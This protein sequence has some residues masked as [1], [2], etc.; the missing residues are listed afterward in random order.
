M[1]GRQPEFSRPLAVEDI[2]KGVRR[3]I[4]ATAEELQALAARMKLPAIHALQATLEVVPERHGSFLVR[5][6]MRAQVAQECVRTLDV[7]DAEVRADIER[8]FVPADSPAAQALQAAATVE[9]DAQA[10]DAPDVIHGEEIDLGELVAEYLAL[11]LDPWPKKPGTEHVDIEVGGET[12]DMTER[13]R[14]PFAV[15]DSL[16]RKE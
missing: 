14:H 3:E 1:S 9:L 11:S 8:L 7:F 2:G 6:Q 16:R 5:G 15:L 10:P 4:S 13:S 12:E